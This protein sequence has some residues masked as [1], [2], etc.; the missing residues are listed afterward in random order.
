MTVKFKRALIGLLIAAVVL[1]GAWWIVDR[2]PADQTTRKG[3]FPMSEKI[4][5]SDAEWR[6]ILTEEQFRVAREKGTERAFKNQYHDNKEPGVYYCVCCGLPLFDAASKFD[7]R[8]GWPSFF[9]PI[10]ERNVSEV[11]DNGFWMKR[12]EIVCSR[13]DAHLGHVFPDGPQPTGLR[14]C[15]NSAALNFV[16][17]EKK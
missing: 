11:S 14:Y 7:S 2:A 16:P 4:H 1:L 5:R 12:T 10:E 15:M 9:K 17:K 3:G 8:T 6:E 13:C